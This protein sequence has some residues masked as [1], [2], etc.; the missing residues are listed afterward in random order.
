MLNQ[1]RGVYSSLQKHNVRY[2]TI[3]GVAAILHGVPPTTF[4]L[5]ILIEATL[6]NAQHLLDALLDA[7]LATAEMTTAEEVLKHEITIFRD[8]IRIDVQTATPGIEFEEA[9]R[10]KE[11]MKYR[12]QEFYVVSREDLIVSKRAAGREKDLED[13]RLLGLR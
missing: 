5:D 3:G 8:R 10:K 13:I 1:L 4:D 6:E 12:R 11:V 7:G 9:W 2:V